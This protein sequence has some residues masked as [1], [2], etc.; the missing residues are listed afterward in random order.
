MNILGV[1]MLSKI[2]KWGII[3]MPTL[4]HYCDKCRKELQLNEVIPIGTYEN[5][6]IYCKYCNTKLRV[7]RKD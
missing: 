6:K 3:N 7:I 2:W 4:I 1:P 5:V